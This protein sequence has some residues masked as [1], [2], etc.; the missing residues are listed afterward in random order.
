MQPEEETSISQIVA[1]DIN[2]NNKRSILSRKNLSRIKYAGN[3]L[4]YTTKKNL[5]AYDLSQQKERTILNDAQKEPS[6]NMKGEYYVGVVQGDKTSYLYRFANTPPQLQ[7]LELKID[8]NQIMWSNQER[9]F[10]HIQDQTLRTFTWN[11][12]SVTRK[13]VNLQQLNIKYPYISTDSQDQ[14]LFL[15]TSQSALYRMVSG[16]T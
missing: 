12:D 3:K 5:Y 1:F 16:R 8:P 14:P 2:G 10:L 7:P 11:D 13:S 15:N 9:A 4:F 6:F